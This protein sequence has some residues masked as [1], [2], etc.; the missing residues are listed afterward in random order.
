MDG[1]QGLRS[2]TMAGLLRLLLLSLLATVQ[3]RALKPRPYR[4]VYC[5]S[6]GEG[7][8][9]AGWAWARF[10]MMIYH[11]GM[12]TLSVDISH[13]CRKCLTGCTAIGGTERVIQSIELMG[14]I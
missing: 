3:A 12:F 10:A 8:F 13:I 6:A 14:I 11:E 9:D 4:V 1:L 5:S 7:M 2:T